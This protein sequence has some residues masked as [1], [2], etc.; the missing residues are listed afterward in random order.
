MVR[1]YEA[2]CG[3]G[4]YFLCSVFFICRG[5]DDPLPAYEVVGVD[6]IFDGTL[7]LEGE[8]LDADG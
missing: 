6:F 1:G 4:D 3:S 5:V 2:D 7:L 8:D